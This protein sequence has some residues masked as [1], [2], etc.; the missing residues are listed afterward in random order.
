MNWMAFSWLMLLIVFLVM[1]ANTVSLVSIWFAAGAL[2]A[3]LASLCGAQVWLQ[4]TL[5]FGVSIAL[6]LLLRPVFR[7]YIKPNLTKT[8]VDAVVGS[9]GIVTEDI[10]NIA[11]A[12]QVKVGAMYWSA[13]SEDNTCIPAGTLVTV[14][15]IEGV[16]VMVTPVN[17]P[18]QTK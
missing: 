13:R 15:R 3:M 9:R 11:A 7:R 10:D 6:L 18:V 16:K 8:N 1:E 12:G 17:E 5:F 2:T 4:G 14:K